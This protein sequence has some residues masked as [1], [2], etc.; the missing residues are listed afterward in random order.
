MLAPLW[1]YWGACPTPL[2][3]PSSYAY[4][5]KPTMYSMW[6]FICYHYIGKMPCRTCEQV[7]L[8]LDTIRFF[9][10]KG[11]HCSFTNCLNLLKKAK[12]WTTKRLIRGFFRIWLLAHA[13]RFVFIVVL[14]S[15]STCWNIYTV[16]VIIY[17]FQGAHGLSRSRANNGKYLMYQKINNLNPGKK[18]G[19]ISCL[20]SPIWMP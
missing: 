5:T 16:K 7:S 2:A 3:G 4:G 12:K 17:R 13:V 20:T 1:N 18:I 6:Y 15:T 8:K 14:T 9:S 19:S 11:P 10:D